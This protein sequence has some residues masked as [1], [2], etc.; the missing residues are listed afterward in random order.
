[1]REIKD[2][3]ILVTG[4]TDGLGQKVATDL[5]EKGATLL[6]HGRDRDK[7]R[8]VQ[9]KIH[10]ATGND[11]LYYYNADLS[12]LDEVDA[13][14]ALVSK[15]CSRL[16]VLINNAGVGA[17][18]DP[19][20]RQVSSD[21]F[22]LRFAVNYLAP[23]LL[24]RRLLPLLRRTATEAG[25][26]RVVNVASV[27][28]RDIDFD[29]VMLEREY[30]GMRAYAQSKQALI[31]FTMDLAEELAGTGVTA[32]VLHPASLMDTNMV[33]E[34]FGAARTTVEEGA[35][36]VERLALSEELKGVSGVYF[37]QSREARVSE[38]A[39]D[40]EARRRLR[41]LSFKWTRA[42]G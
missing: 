22:E 26:A 38:Q 15:R 41:E 34:W 36:H 8:M 31:M 9:A 24:T 14:A 7:G 37:D 40:L 23:F 33:R 3:V 6:L 28:Q 10:K 30:D 2:M 19:A 5:A 35:L 13:L 20:R 21:G 12:S 27:A 4:A 18:P 42:G 29:D 25:E 1:M 17:G 32:N 16:D 39:Y 11:R